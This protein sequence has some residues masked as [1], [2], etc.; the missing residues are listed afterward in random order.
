MSLPVTNDME[1]YKCKK[2]IWLQC[3]IELKIIFFK[4]M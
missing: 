3:S 4:F 2:L 1:K